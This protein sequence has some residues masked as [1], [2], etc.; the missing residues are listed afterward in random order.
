[1]GAQGMAAIKAE[2]GIT[3]A[4]DQ[5]S[6]AHHGMPASAIAAGCVDRILPPDKMARELTRISSLPFG[7][8]RPAA[9][10]EESLAASGD[11]FQEIFPLLQRATG[12]DFSHYKPAT[13]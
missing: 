9:D 6:A 5:A 10:T 2:G 3:F 8:Y 12:I 4:Q 11:R 13:I 7:G 1:D